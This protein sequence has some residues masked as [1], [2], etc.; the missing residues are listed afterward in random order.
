M[1]RSPSVAFGGLAAPHPYAGRHLGATLRWRGCRSTADGGSGM[2]ALIPDR[3]AGVNGVVGRSVMR[4]V[5]W[6]WH[7]HSRKRMR[8]RRRRV[9]AEAT[10]ATKGHDAVCPYADDG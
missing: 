3:T 9:R 5:A 4:T 8:M 6:R 1:S 2:T 7:P 10:N